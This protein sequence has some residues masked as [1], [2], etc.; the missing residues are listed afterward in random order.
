MSNILSKVWPILLAIY[1]ISP[2]DAHPLFF[3]DLIAAGIMLYLMYRNSRQKHRK[4]YSY[5]GEEKGEE[6]QKTSESY[7]N[8]EDAYRL[9]GVSSG[10]TLDEI[11]KAYKEK[12]IK[13][14]PDK[15]NHLSKELQDKAKEITLR[16]NRAFETI[17]KSRGK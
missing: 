1:I 17:E 6:E 10:S 14:H 13:S 15:V 2:F 3:D 9:L 12:V 8:I 5:T 4:G 7:L 11:K 16:L